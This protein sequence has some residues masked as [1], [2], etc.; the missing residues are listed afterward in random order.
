MKR[1]LDIAYKYELIHGCI[2]IQCHI[3]AKFRCMYTLSHMLRHHT[4]SL[5]YETL[6]Y[7]C[8]GSVQA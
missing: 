6:E 3:H 1:C 4:L 8:V 7:E 2:C 5:D